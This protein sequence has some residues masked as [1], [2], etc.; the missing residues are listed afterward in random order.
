[1]SADDLAA[2][3]ERQLELKERFISDRGYWQENWDHVLSL[4]PDYF[5]AYLSFSSVSWTTGTLEPKVKELLYLA[6]NAGLP[7][8]RDESKQRSGDI[9]A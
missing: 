4:D 1:M 7:I 3:S 6:L 5:E 2:H 9:E 8:F